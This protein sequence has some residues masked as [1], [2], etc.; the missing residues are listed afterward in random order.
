MTF[1]SRLELC[2]GILVFFLICVAVADSHSVNDWERLIETTIGPRPG[3]QP[4][5]TSKENESSS[6]NQLNQMSIIELLI[7]MEELHQEDHRMTTEG[8]IVL[9]N[10]HAKHEIA[11]SLLASKTDLFQ[12][13]KQF[14]AL[15]QSSPRFAWE[16]F[17][18]TYAGDSVLEQHCREVITYVGE[19]SKSDCRQQQRINEL[20]LQLVSFLQSERRNS[21]ITDQVENNLRKG[22]EAFH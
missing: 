20:E 3:F 2:M 16:L 10:I 8:A 9:K 7:F 22:S 11:Q 17:C 5:S 15:D 19:L 14:R 12:A 21:S 6:M 18:R 1:S 4:G 13:A